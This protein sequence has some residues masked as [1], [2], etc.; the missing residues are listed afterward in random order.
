M[1]VDWYF[2]GM[3]CSVIIYFFLLMIEFDTVCM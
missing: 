2:Y 1:L 3:M